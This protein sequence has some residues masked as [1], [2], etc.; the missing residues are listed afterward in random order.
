[1]VLVPERLQKQMTAIMRCQHIAT[2]ECVILRIS[3]LVEYTSEAG[4]GRVGGD[5]WRDGGACGVM[6]DFELN[7]TF[8]GAGL[9]KRFM[10]F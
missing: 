1:M 5:R 8:R 9:L 10:K 6:R 2:R 4:V 3:L 7:C